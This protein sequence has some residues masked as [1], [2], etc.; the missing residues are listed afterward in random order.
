VA[1]AL[2]PTILPQGSLWSYPWQVL[3]GSAAFIVISK[4]LLQ[5][6]QVSVIEG[7]STD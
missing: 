6:E 2:L 3:F 5:A 7:T 1:I 4:V